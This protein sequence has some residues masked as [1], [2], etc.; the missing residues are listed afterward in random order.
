MIAYA[1]ARRTQEIGIRVA[2]G[3]N[4]ADI[5]QMVF[6]NA[7]LPVVVGIALGV[8]VAVFAQRAISSE[9]YGVAGTDP[10]TYLAAAALMLIVGAAACLVP[11][12]RAT[13]VDP[14]VALRYE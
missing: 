9:L 7:L 5:L 8:P 6:R 12:R 3:A 11:A 13:R 14:I 2:M 10:L 4:R 1:V